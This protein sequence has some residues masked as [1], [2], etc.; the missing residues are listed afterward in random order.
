MA[1]SSLVTVTGLQLVNEWLSFRVISTEESGFETNLSAARRS[2]DCPSADRNHS[3]SAARRRDPPSADAA[4]AQRTCPPALGPPPACRPSLHLRAMPCSTN[5]FSSASSSRLWQPRP[6]SASP[7]P[8]RWRG[9]AESSGTIPLMRMDDVVQLTSPAR[10][11]QGRA[12]V[13]VE[14]VSRICVRV[15]GWFCG[16]DIVGAAGH[17]GIALRSS[18]SSASRARRSASRPGTSLIRSATAARASGPPA[19]RIARPCRR[20]ADL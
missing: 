18:H 9:L 7:Q 5:C 13:R 10:E 20:M 4:T 1:T 11:R 17:W 6:G 12:R 14:A 19:S 2:P 15:G 16:A 3:V 8:H